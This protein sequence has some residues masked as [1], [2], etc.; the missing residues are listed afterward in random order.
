MRGPSVWRGERLADSDE[1]IHEWTRSEIAELEGALLAVQ[2]LARPLRRI[3]RD[4]CP[5]SRLASTLDRLRGELLRGRGFVLLRGLDAAKYTHEEIA[6][7]F[8]VIG[9]HLGRALPQNAGG[10]LLGH[11]KDL[12]RDVR[13][14]TSRIYQTRARQ[15]YHTDSADIVGL[16]CLQPAMDGGRSALASAS[17]IHNALFESSPDLLAELFDP[18]CTDHRGEYDDRAK[19]YFTA[20]VL[21]WY[22]QELS[23]LYQRK[24]IESAQRFEGVPRLTGRQVAALDA[25]DRAADDPAIHLEMDLQ[26]GDIQFIH[27]HQMLHDRSAFSDW[28]EPGRR[29]HLLRLWLCPRDGRPL[30]PWF[31]ERLHSAEPGQRGGVVLDGV[32]PVVSLGP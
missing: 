7:L 5:L 31:A 27:N 24:Y 16:L 23:V 14:P 19:P 12:G 29:R 10:D 13:E 8:W 17:A 6:T 20:P 26:C 18:F 21:S 25:F 9:A 3:G 11:V 22:A 2:A 4:H 32:E 15:G 28:P 30:P 1:W